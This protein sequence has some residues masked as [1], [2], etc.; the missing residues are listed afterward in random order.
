MS[1]EKAVRAYKYPN[2]LIAMLLAVLVTGAG[3]D[4]SIHYNSGMSDPVMRE[5]FSQ[6]F[7]REIISHIGNALIPAAVGIIVASSRKIL[8]HS[9]PGV[10]DDQDFLDYAA[11]VGD[12]GAGGATM[13]TIFASEAYKHNVDGPGDILTTGIFFFLGRFLAEMILHNAG[14]GRKQMVRN[15]ADA[16]QFLSDI[17][18]DVDDVFAK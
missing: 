10:R 16:F 3:V 14:V 2:E 6:I 1:Q 18:S 12:I 17:S 8:S 15:S 4:F 5:F 11:K 9:N 13:A 7:G